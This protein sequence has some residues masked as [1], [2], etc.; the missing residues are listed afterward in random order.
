MKSVIEKSI[1]ESISKEMNEFNDYYKK[2]LNSNVKLINTVIN[3][4][5][6]QKGKQLRPSIC[7]LSANL[8]GKANKNTFKAAAR[9]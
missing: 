9:K 7:I 4:I 6:R 3:Y 5:T 8:C 2:T 1:I